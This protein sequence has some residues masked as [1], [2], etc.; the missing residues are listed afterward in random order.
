MTSFAVPDQSALAIILAFNNSAELPRKLLRK[1]GDKSL[2]AHALELVSALSWIKRS[3][4]ASDDDEIVLVAER[5]GFEGIL[6]DRGQLAGELAL[7]AY[8]VDMVDP[9][10]QS[11][12]FLLLLSASAPLIRPADLDKAFSLLK[13]TKAD[14]VVS[15]RK[16]KQATWNLKGGVFI[17]D[18]DLE[19]LNQPAEIEMTEGFVVCRRSNLAESLLGQQVERL[20][21][22]RDRAVAVRDHHDWWVCEKLLSRKKV[23]FVVAGNQRLGMGHVY[24]TLSIAHELTD[25]DISFLCTKESDLAVNYITS[26]YYPSEMQLKDDLAEEVIARGPDLV[27]NDILDTEAE[28]IGAL[29][30]AGLKVVNFEDQGKGAERADL[31]INELFENPDLRPQVKAGPDYFCLRDE[32][33]Q[34]KPRPF[35]E[36]VENVLITFGGVDPAD[37]TRRV[38][39][40]IGPEAIRREIRVHAITGP[41]YLFGPKLKELIASFGS[42]QI[43]LKEATKRISE[44]MA[45]ADL[46]ISAA[47]RTVYE[48]AHMLVPT[49][50]IAANRTEEK[51]HFGMKGVH[52]RLDSKASEEAI[53]QSFLA[54]A[55]NPKRRLAMR[56]AMEKMDF[57][58]GMKRVVGEIRAVLKGQGNER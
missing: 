29:K 33:F 36:K 2:L 35:R 22:P 45:Q 21:L 1:L 13:R 7:A 23:L 34:V 54:L 16:V 57:T 56:Q 27:I 8:V 3:V 15:A 19:E 31:V 49:I 41:G 32:F 51:H 4:V 40:A 52:L 48:L 58:S 50:V 55:D 39:R 12:D 14:S 6:V 38:L 24:R 28:Y 46:A 11:G 53:R 10:G 44:Y 9:Q 17:A 42:E 47:G 30:A 37:L 43:R 5:S 25:E 26:Q 18:Y 20:V